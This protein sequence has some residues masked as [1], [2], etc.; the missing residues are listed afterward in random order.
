MVLDVRAMFI[1]SLPQWL[2]IIE[3]RIIRGRINLKNFLSK[4]NFV[5]KSLK[6]IQWWEVWTS[7]LPHPPTPHISTQW[8]RTEIHK[9]FL[10][11]WRKWW[12][13]NVVEMKFLF[14]LFVHCHKFVKIQKIL[15][16]SGKCFT[17]YFPQKESKA[18]KM[19]DHYGEK[20]KPVHVEENYDWKTRYSKS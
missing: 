5:Y 2:A 12:K 4:R 6:K 9:I 10:K 11:S 7:W 14:H 20:N 16:Y 1:E 15:T 19:I 8:R 18:Y 17:W 3:S 13:E